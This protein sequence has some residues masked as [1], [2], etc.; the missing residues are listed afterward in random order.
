MVDFG[1]D[2]ADYTDVDPLFGDLATFDR[3]VA[4]AHRLG[5]RVIVDWV[6]NHSSDRHP[7]F[8]ASRSSRDDPRRDWYVW[9]DGRPGGRPPNDWSLAL[10]RR[11]RVDPRPGDGAV[12]PARL[13]IRPARSQLG[14]PR[15][16]VGHAG[17]AALL[18]GQG[19]Q[20]LSHRCRPGAR[21]RTRPPSP[22]TPWPQDQ[23][24]PQGHAIMR[25][26]RGVL[27]E[28]DDRMAVGEVYVLDQRRV[29]SFLVTGDELHL[30]HNFVFLRCD[31]SAD[32]FRAVIEEFGRVA[33]APAWPAWFLENH[34]HSRVATRYGPGRA[35]CGGPAGAR[36]ARL[37]LPLPRA[38]ARA[39][40]RPH[41]RRGRRQP[42]RARP[43]AG[44]GPLGA[45]LGRRT[46]CGVHHRHALAAAGRAIAE[47]LAARCSA[48][49]PA[50][51]CRSG[52][53]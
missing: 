40:R 38:G 24:W 11:S 29:A 14:E 3:L 42:R 10:R 52:G 4:E 39:A 51:T 37:R 26:V 46:G 7:W 25:R 15:G 36:P 6:P 53:G 28:Y 8:E 44:A 41:P 49:T 43:R 31:W 35:R 1:Y 2:V 19:R 23:D 13:R 21:E 5:I 45:A 30:A 9:R 27:E 50:R 33:P 34:D 12:V 32:A 47:R 17:H 48:T 20:R 18:A 22:A 16:G